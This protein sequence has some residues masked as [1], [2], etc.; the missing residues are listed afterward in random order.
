MNNA[1]VIAKLRQALEKGAGAE[2]AERRRTQHAA[3]EPQV[4]QQRNHSGGAS[5]RRSA[6]HEANAGVPDA[7]PDSVLSPPV[8][9]AR[10]TRRS[11]CPGA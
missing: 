6:R 7:P 4:D 3:A 1:A 9:A 5:R 2:L 11:G 8:S 10:C